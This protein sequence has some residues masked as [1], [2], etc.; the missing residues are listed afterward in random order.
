MRELANRLLSGD[1]RALARAITLVEADDPRCQELLRHV[2]SDSGGAVTIGV[3]GS[4]G[5]GKSTLIDKLVESE[6]ARDRSV[7]VLSVDPSS[8]FTSGA[9]LGDRLR[10]SRHFL[11]PGVFI[12]SMASRGATGGLARATRSAAT[13]AD[14]AGAEVILIETVGVGQ[15]DVDIVTSVDSV[16]LVLMPGAGDAVQALKSGIMEIPDV[17]VINRAADPRA[18]ETFRHVREAVSLRRRQGWQPPIIRT[19]ATTGEGFDDLR[20]ALDRHREYLSA[21]GLLRDRRRQIARAQ[22]SSILM[23]EIVARVEAAIATDPRIGSLIDDVADRRLDPVTA[24]RLVREA[25]AYADKA[26]RQPADHPT[27]PE[28]ALTGGD[29]PGE[30]A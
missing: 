2:Y 8:P 21:N 16:V 26:G 1:R 14:A 3:T 27:S 30:G 11:D 10:M 17:I 28:R 18:A 25:V 4:P 22:V 24:A 6:R 29:A 19:E 15:V 12:R 23:A 5:V 9:I 7:V 20:H 13:L